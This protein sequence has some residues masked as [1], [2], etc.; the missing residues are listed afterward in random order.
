MKTDFII[1]GISKGCGYVWDGK[2]FVTEPWESAR[3]FKS[4]T[5]ADK[6]VDRLYGAGE[7]SVEMATIAA[8]RSA[9]SLLGQRAAGV[10]KTI[11]DEERAARAER[12]AAARKKRWA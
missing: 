5:A 2:A 10:K 3:R 6:A 8:P 9:A 11:T 4:R 12:M 7:R 1:I